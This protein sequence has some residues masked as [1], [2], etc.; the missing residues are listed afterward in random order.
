MEDSVEDL[1]D[2]ILSATLKEVL[3]F[4]HQAVLVTLDQLLDLVPSAVFGFALYLSLFQ[5]QKLLL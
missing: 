4:V 1:E 2:L 3:L 5:E